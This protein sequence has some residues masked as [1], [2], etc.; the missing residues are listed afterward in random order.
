[1]QTLLQFCFK[2]DIYIN[3]L[4]KEIKLTIKTAV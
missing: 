2:K 1:M 4:L 3:G